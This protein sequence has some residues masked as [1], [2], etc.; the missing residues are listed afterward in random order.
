[1]QCCR[2]FQLIVNPEIVLFTEKPVS[3]CVVSQPLAHTFNPSCW[4]TD[5]LLAHT[6]NPK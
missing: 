3:S 2:I 1:M 4:N 6:F 5:T